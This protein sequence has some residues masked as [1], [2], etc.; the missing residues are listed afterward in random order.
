VTR[1]RTD[2]VKELRLRG[3]SMIEVAMPTQLK[4]KCFVFQAASDAKH[5]LRSMRTDPGTLTA[6]RS[7]STFLSNRFSFSTSAD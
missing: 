1:Y 7:Q 6:Q 4:C 3:I 2:F 5:R